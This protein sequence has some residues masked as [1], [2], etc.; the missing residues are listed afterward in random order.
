[1]VFPWPERR[2]SPARQQQVALQ[3]VALQQVA[4]QQV[5]TPALPKRAGFAMWAVS[6]P[7]SSASPRA[8]RE[9]AR[10]ARMA[11]LPRAW[12]QSPRRT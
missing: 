3:Q 10:Q 9:E 8:R 1:M 2:G 12:V 7:K 5:A 6:R 4:L 11:L